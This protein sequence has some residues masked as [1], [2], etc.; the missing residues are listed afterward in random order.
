[1]SRRVA[2]W[3]LVFDAQRADSIHEGCHCQVEISVLYQ[4][5][6]QEHAKHSTYTPW[7]SIST[8][9]WRGE[10]GPSNT[11]P[12][13]SPLAR[14]FQNRTNS[15]GRV[16][17]YDTGR[18]YKQQLGILKLLPQSQLVRS[19]KALTNKLIQSAQGRLK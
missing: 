12:D 9:V 17:R 6:C 13:P 3:Q 4:G 5:N 11:S 15:D 2:E 14:L 1:M 19:S 7:N 18:R 10:I 8:R 16:S